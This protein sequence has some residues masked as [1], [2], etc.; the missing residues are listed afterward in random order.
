MIQTLILGHKGMLGNAVLKYFQTQYPEEIKSEI[1]EKRWPSE[2]FKKKLFDFKGDFL[3]NCIA[4]VPNRG[5]DFNVNYDL[6]VWLD[7][8]VECK[9][10]YPNTDFEG[11]NNEYGKSKERISKYLSKKSKKTK[12][13]KTSIIGHSH[14]HR[15]GL[16][17]WFLG[18]QGQVYGYTKVF[19]NGVTTLQWS[20]ECFELMKYWENYQADTIISSEKI[21]KFDL[22][23]KIK[24][25]YG[26]KIEILPKSSLERDECLE[27]L[28]QAPD[29]ESQLNSLRKF[30]GL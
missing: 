28:I 23:K 25:V 14:N 12:M 8:N 17:D 30:Y 6:P 26:K 13:L 7:K 1:I 22:L 4:I 3:I 27:G 15:N 2:E 10:I 24:K 16:L 21:S 5:G 19:W 29:I 11:L 18:S 20:K 9:I